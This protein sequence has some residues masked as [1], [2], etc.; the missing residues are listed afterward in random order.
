M[1]VPLEVVHRAQHFLAAVGIHGFHR[2]RLAP[3]VHVRL[4]A[5][6]ARRRLQ[7]I[8]VL[9]DGLFARGNVE[10]ESARDIKELQHGTARG[11]ESLRI[12]VDAHLHLVVLHFL[13]HRVHV[14]FPAD[15]R[16]REHELPGIWWVDLSHLAH[17]PLH[18]ETGTLLMIVRRAGQSGDAVLLL[19]DVRKDVVDDLATGGIRRLDL[20][21]AHPARL[22]EPGFHDRAKPFVLRLRRH[23]VFSRTND[24]VRLTELLR[25]LPLG[26]VW[27]RDGRRHVLRIA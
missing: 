13:T 23:G 6:E 18:E 14:Y 19:Q 5:F 12:E 24:Q 27:K 22:G 11:D 16:A 20:D 9:G 21:R 17:R 7:H 3:Q 8:E 26:R 2:H 4:K 1:P 10:I 25:Q 15:L